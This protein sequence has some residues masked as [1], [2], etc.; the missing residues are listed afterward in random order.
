VSINGSGERGG[1][2]GGR[3]AAAA[4]AEVEPEVEE[5]EWD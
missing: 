5:D 3:T 1:L 4:A 2:Y